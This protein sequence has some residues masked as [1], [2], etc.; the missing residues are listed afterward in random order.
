MPRGVP[1]GTRI[2]GRQKG[3]LNK[4]TADVKT[5]AQVYTEEAVNALAVI[6]RTSESDAAKVAAIKEL[7]DRGH[8]KATQTMAVDANVKATVHKIEREIVRSPNPDRRDI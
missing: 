4:V 8:G 2:G 3:T 7:L 5:V 1:K 6:M